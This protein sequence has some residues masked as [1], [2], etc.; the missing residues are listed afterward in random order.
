MFSSFLKN[1]W[2]KYLYVSGQYHLI[3]LIGLALVG[4]SV[5]GYQTPRVISD[6]YEALDNKVGVKD[7]LYLL[8]F[9]AFG[10]YLSSTVYQLSL[11]RYIQLLLNK[12][13]STSYRNWI[14]TYESVGVGNF[15]SEKYPMGE[16]IA[17]ILND[18][19]AVI[20]MVSSGSF[21]IFIDMAFIISCLV[22]F[23]GLNTT[24]GMALISAEVLVCAGLVY[25]SKK[26]AKVYMAVR[27]ST[28]N[29]N[30]SVANL[31]GGLRYS[32]Y[33]PNNQYASSRS[34][35]AFD[36]FLKKQLTANVWD[37]G[38]FSIAE[39]LFPILLA[40]LVMIFPY[41]QIVEMATIAAII[42]LIQRSITPIKE[43]T[44]KISS[45][46]RAL[47]GV[48]R[49]QEFNDDLETLSRSDLDENLPEITKF[50]SLKVKVDSFTYPKLKEADQEFSLKNIE[51][52][53][54][55]GQLIGL[56]GMS[57]SG[58]STLLKILSTDI[59]ASESQIDLI[60]LHHK[61]SFG[62]EK[63][64]ALKEYKK[65]VSIVSQD[66]HVFSESLKFNITFGQE[67]KEGFDRFWKNCRS[68]LPYLQSWQIKPED[69]LK[70]NQ[71]SLGQKQLISALRSCYLKKPIVLFDEISSGL[72]SKLEESLRE[73]VLMIQS[74]SLTIIVAHRVETIFKADKI[75]VMEQGRVNQI[76][77]HQDLLV[78]SKV[79][80]DFVR[81]VGLS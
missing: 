59:I 21:R 33:T 69:T 58:K 76:G 63:L 34:I 10:D 64:S 31:A 67:T 42:D 28:G 48:K 9:I 40:L 55:K 62:G 80:N 51:F 27:N 71:L 39:S 19:E 50:Q 81:E 72:D 78:A 43:I 29:L 79:Y 17:R 25:G 11:N 7:V 45:I 24:A 35:D 18:T 70:K 74:H 65:Q 20:E 5:L 4:A 75:L 15:G 37:A 6:L 49:I 60:G 3:F 54:E 1:K 44:G 38:Y 22:S 16:V 26:M 68:R 23:I 57:G 56:V 14:E 47:T 32:F 52:E 30:R 41:S 12:I 13:R 77:T 46:Q 2:Y 73:L 61:I 66:S 36:D 8:G 53:G